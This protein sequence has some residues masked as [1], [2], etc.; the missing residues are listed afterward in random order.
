VS[1]LSVRHGWT[2][3]QDDQRACT[4]ETANPRHAFGTQC[5]KRIEVEAFMRT[6]GIRSEGKARA[7]MFIESFAPGSLQTLAMAVTNK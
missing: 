3:R 6:H 5:F 1:T 7:L 2:I 4:C